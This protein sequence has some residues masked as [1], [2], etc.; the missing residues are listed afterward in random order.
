MLCVIIDIPASISLGCPLVEVG[1]LGDQN[2]S[3]DFEKALI[4]N[5]RNISSLEVVERMKSYP[6]TCVLVNYD[7]LKEVV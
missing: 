1:Q 6:K 7:I 5:L 4:I 2:F 3:T